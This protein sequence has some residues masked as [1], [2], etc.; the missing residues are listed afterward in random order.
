LLFRCIA[1]ASATFV[2]NYDFFC[3]NSAYCRK[4]L[5]DEGQAR[6]VFNLV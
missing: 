2:I 6:L 1:L 3:Y 5:L 4:P